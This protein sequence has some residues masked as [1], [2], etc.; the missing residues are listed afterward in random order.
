MI[1]DYLDESVSLAHRLGTPDAYG[2]DAYAAAVTVVAR[3]EQRMRLVPNEQGELVR[4]ELQVF[5]APTVAASEGD[6][7]TFGGRTARVVAVDRQR[8]LGAT[9]QIVLHCGSE[10]SV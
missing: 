3:V 9:F 4:S 1:E 10:G 8:G 7:V 6:R 5:L 2:Q